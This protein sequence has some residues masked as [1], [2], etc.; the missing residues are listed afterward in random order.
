MCRYW[1]VWA[2]WAPELA[3]V[4]AGVLCHAACRGD[5]APSCRRWSRVVLHRRE[6]L[7]LQGILLR[8]PREPAQD[9][10]PFAYLFSPFLSILSFTLG[11]SNVSYSTFP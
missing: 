7:L 10:V 5:P 11:F 3:G 4:H 1:G 6:V 2:E 8:G 9:R